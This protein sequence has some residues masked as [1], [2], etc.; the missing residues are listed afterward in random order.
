MGL[1]ES[2]SSLQDDIHLHA[3]KDMLGELARQGIALSK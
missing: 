3:E 2:I 1:R